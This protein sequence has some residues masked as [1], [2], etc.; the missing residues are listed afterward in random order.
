[1]D[2]EELLKRWSKLKCTVAIEAEKACDQNERLAFFWR[3]LK[4]TE[5]L[6]EQAR[7]E[8]EQLAHMGE[9]IRNEMRAA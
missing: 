1:M 8:E 5:L 3:Q 2:I 9:H 4:D 7:H 6:I